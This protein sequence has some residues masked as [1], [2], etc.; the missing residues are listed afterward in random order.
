MQRQILKRQI[1]G[2]LAPISEPSLATTSNWKQQQTLS[3]ACTMA[4][5][6]T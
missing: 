4:L 2:L 6:H 1:T 5:I 3:E